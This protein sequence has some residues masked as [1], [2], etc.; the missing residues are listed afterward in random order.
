MKCELLDKRK[1]PITEFKFRESVKQWEGR[2][3]HKVSSLMNVTHPPP[4]LIYSQFISNVI[5]NHNTAKL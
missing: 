2:A 3:W 4:L 5:S 1:E